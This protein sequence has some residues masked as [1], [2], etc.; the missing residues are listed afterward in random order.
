[1]QTFR[2]VTNWLPPLDGESSE[3]MEAAEEVAAEEEDDDEATDSDVELIVKTRGQKRKGATAAEKKSAAPVIEVAES[4]TDGAEFATPAK[5]AK[6][7]SQE[8]LKV[9]DEMLQESQERPVAKVG[10]VLTRPVMG[11]QKKGDPI[12]VSRKLPVAK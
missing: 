9:K 3:G 2:D 4:D 1:M 6:N 5:R 11:E 10:I 7:P 8:A 12:V